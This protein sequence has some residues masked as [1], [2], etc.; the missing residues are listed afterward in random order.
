MF[1][2]VLLTPNSTISTPGTVGVQF[3]IALHGALRTTGTGTPQMFSP[4]PTTGLGTVEFFSWLLLSVPT[5]NTLVLNVS[6]SITVGQ[7][8]NTRY[9]VYTIV[10]TNP[11]AG[12]GIL[13]DPQF[14]GLRGQLFQ[15]HG[16]DGVVYNIISD[17]LFQLNARFAFLAES[18]S[19][20]VML[21]TGMESDA[22]WSQPGS[23]L[24][25]LASLP[26]TA[27]SCSSWQE[28]ETRASRRSM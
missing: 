9:H 3:T 17:P 13:G 4:D 1:F 21:S 28:L 15:V 24:S 8:V 11:A 18:Q 2:N 6:E 27:P 23:Y 19:C 14:V 10:I 26:S 5:N 22:C 12:P 20:P 25:Q 16:I 7:D